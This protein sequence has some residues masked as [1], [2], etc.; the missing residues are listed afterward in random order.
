MESIEDMYRRIL[1]DMLD[2]QTGIASGYAAR[3]RTKLN[4]PAPVAPKTNLPPVAPK[5]P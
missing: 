1:D 3:L 4:L 5:Q 2:P